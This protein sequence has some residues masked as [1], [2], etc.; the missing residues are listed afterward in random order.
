MRRP[1]V[2]V[3]LHY[4]ITA[5]ASEPD[6]EHRLLA[7]TMLAFLRHAELSGEWLAPGL[8]EQ[9]RPL[10]LTVAQPDHPL[11]PTEIWGV[12][13]NELRPALSCTVTLTLDPHAP[14]RIPLVR[15]RELRLS[16]LDVQSVRQQANGAGGAHTGAEAALF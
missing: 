13:D 14:I 12:L 15:T 2:R 5:W 1:E 10:L 6:D 11:N 3:D 9:P 7:R 8:R 16:D 4:M